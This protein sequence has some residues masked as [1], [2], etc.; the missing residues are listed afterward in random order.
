[1]WLICLP[2]CLY[3]TIGPLLGSSHSSPLQAVSA[4]IYT[5]T[6]IVKYNRL[7][8]PILSWRLII[9]SF[10]R[11]FS[12]IRLIQEGLPVASKS[13]SLVNCLVKLAQEKSVVR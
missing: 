1:M 4:K 9:K 10:L 6:I 3:R 2:F 12:S 11:P 7:H 8:G 5:Y 13:M